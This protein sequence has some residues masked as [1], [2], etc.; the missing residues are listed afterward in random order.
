[1]LCA[2]F[3]VFMKYLFFLL[4]GIFTAGYFNDIVSTVIIVISIVCYFILK[5]KELNIRQIIILIIAGAVGFS[6]YCVSDSVISKSYSGVSLKNTELTVTVLTEP[7]YSYNT[8]KFEGKVDGYRGKATITLYDSPYFSCYDKIRLKGNIYSVTQN[9]QKYFS[10]GI[11]YKVTSFDKDIEI[12]RGKG[13][14]KSVINFKKKVLYTIDNVFSNNVAVFIKGVLVGDD[15]LNNYDLNNS[16][17]KLGLSHIVSVSG[18]HFSI[19]TGFVL[20]ILRR[21]YLKRKI[22][23]LLT[24]PVSFLLAIFIGF[25]PSVVRVLITVT[26]LSLA[27]LF[28]RDRIHDTY[29]LLLVAVLMVVFNIYYIHNIAFILSF[30][31]LAGILIYTKK[32]IAKIKRIPAG[33]ADAV[34]VTLSANISTMPFII[35]YFKGLPVLSVLANAVVV[36][37]MSVIMIYAIIV[38]CI[39]FVMLSVGKILAFP[40]DIVVRMMLDV[41]VYLS[42]LRLSYF[43][44]LSIE[45]WYI[46]LYFL[47]LFIIASGI[48]KFG[49]I[50]ISA[51]LLLF[52]AINIF[53]PLDSVISPYSTIYAAGAEDSGKAIIEYKDKVIF[54]NSSSINQKGFSDI[55]DKYNNRFDVYVAFDAKGLEY[56]HNNKLYADEV[57]IPSDFCTNEYFVNML[58][59]ECG[60]LIPI[61]EDKIL[62]YGDLNLTLNPKDGYN[63]LKA[64]VSIKNKKI[65]FPGENAEYL[66]KNSFYILKY[67]FLDAHRNSEN[68]I[69]CF[70]NR[71]ERIKI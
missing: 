67:Y 50:S 56:F 55:L 41:L 46:S 5:R 39:S 25:T 69:N 59:S 10:R 22:T 60:E 43:S 36:P 38:V 33:I 45:T 20:F 21:L 24:I 40:L 28:N 42:N 16:L 13:F 7:D 15:R 65:V 66:D 12:E 19:I 11:F 8:L 2:F 52:F 71:V 61:K 29:L 30:T 70:E 9:T 14:L 68:V 34:A 26:V 54:I 23:S 57:F 51:I 37:L 35:Y 1:M 31:S 32:I 18:M 4:L 47:A 62:Q 6:Y 48:P 63:I 49:K 44:T 3:G 53:Y 58:A 17:K 64:C 27:D